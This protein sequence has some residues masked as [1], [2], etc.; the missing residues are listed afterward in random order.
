MLGICLRTLNRLCV[1][2]CTFTEKSRLVAGSVL[3]SRRRAVVVSTRQRLYR[4]RLWNARPRVIEAQCWRSA[5]TDRSFLN[6]F[7]RQNSNT[8][9]CWGL[10]GL[11][12]FGSERM[13]TMNCGVC[14]SG[15]WTSSTW[16]REQCAPF[17]WNTYMDCQ[18]VGAWL[19]T[20]AVSTTH[21]DNSDHQL[22]RLTRRKTVH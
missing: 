17:C 15:S 18:Q 19:A 2:S 16:R 14:C 12:D 22:S 13:A 21:P 4:R 11:F 8:A 3:P 10:F 7:L 20:F 1:E 6:P 5:V 9:V